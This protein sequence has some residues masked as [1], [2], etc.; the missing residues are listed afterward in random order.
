MRVNSSTNY[1][2]FNTKTNDIKPHVDRKEHYLQEYF[3]KASFAN[4]IKLTR[5][6]KKLVDLS[7]LV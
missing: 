5:R 2:D 4:P 7:L 1:V 3:S 6:S